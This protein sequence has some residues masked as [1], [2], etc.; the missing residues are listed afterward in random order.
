MRRACHGVP[1]DIGIIVDWRSIPVEIIHV[2]M[3]ALHL[4]LVA[5]AV[6]GIDDSVYL[7]LVEEIYIIWSLQRIQACDL[8]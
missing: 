4:Q 2:E 3:K 1:D 6:I 5:C 7:I 8:L